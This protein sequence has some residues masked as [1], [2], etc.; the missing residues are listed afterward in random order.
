MLYDAL[1][2]LCC[3]QTWSCPFNHA[4]P[5]GNNAVLHSHT[6]EMPLDPATAPKWFSF[7]RN[8]F[9]PPQSFRDHGAA[10]KDG[11]GSATG[12]RKCPKK[13]SLLMSIYC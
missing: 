13:Q 2:T 7:V 4:V 10:S 3:S 1:I 8:E 11:G 5:V 12:R 6:V 9:G